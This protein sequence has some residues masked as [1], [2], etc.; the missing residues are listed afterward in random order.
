MTKQKTLALVTIAGTALM[1]SP[2]IAEETVGTQASD[3]MMASQ[4]TVT[5]ATRGE[6]GKKVTEPTTT[7]VSPKEHEALS[8]KIEDK[9]AEVAKTEEELN[10]SQTTVSNLKAEEEAKTKEL[11]E[12]ENTLSDQSQKQADLEQAKASQ[13]AIVTNLSSEVAN[14]QKQVEETPTVVSHRGYNAQYPEATNLAYT[15]AVEDGFTEFETDIRFTKDG[16]P[17]TSHDATIN[18]LAR[19]HDGSRIEG[20]KYVGTYTLNE[21]NQYDYGLYKGE[22]FKGTKL[23]TFDELVDTLSKAG[24]TSLQ[25]ELKDKHTKE[26]KRLLYDTVVK[27]NFEDR[28]SWI[29]F[30]WDYLDDFKEFNPNS[31]FVL[32]AGENK[33][34][35]VDKAKSLDN[36][37]NNVAISMFYPVITKA[38]VDDYKKH[39]YD[40]YAWTVDDQGTAD[41]LVEKGVKGILTD[42]G[43]A[44]GSHFTNDELLKNYQSKQT[45]LSDAKSKLAALH[46]QNFDASDLLAK[47]ELLEFDIKTLSTRSTTE[48]D[49]A[50]ILGQMLERKKAELLDLEKLIK[51][52][53]VVDVPDS[54]P[55]QEEKPILMLNQPQRTAPAGQQIGS[56]TQNQDGKA[57]VGDGKKDKTAS[58]TTSGTIEVSNSMITYTF[59]RVKDDP[60]VSEAPK[61]LDYKPIEKV[62]VPLSRRA[63][64]AKLPNTSTRNSHVLTTLGFASLASLFYVGKRQKRR[65]KRRY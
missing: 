35:L 13:Q 9:K 21:L 55:V 29:S 7:V 41:A 19:N 32:L 47:K 63:A 3:A 15:K 17:V 64:R 26:Q 46:A 48:T 1:A 43:Y 52:Y 40:T 60:K 57:I 36:G 62:Q 11:K 44:I 28:I 53:V 38:L 58:H 34:G 2:V 39:G 42:Q 8:Q 16:I 61:Q 25:V 14:L 4:T 20:D 65:S 49:K 37:K 22:Q 18:R 24:A 54:A 10:Q 50:G 31:K 12:V 59:Q 56:K 45:L 6:E 51:T 27:H 5:T 23:Q 30:Y 33:Q